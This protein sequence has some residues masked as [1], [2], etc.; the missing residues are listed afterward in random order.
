MEP[1]FFREFPI[2][3]APKLFFL[4]RVASFSFSFFLSQE[5][6]LL[7]FV[8]CGSSESLV[9]APNFVREIECKFFPF[10][11]GRTGAKDPPFA[12]FESFLF[13]FPSHRPQKFNSFP[14]LPSSPIDRR[15]E[16]PLGSFFFMTATPVLLAPPPGNSTSFSNPCSQLSPPYGHNPSSIATPGTSPPLCLDVFSPLPT[17]EHLRFSFLRIRRFF[18]GA[19]LSATAP[20]LP[21]QAHKALSFLSSISKDACA[22]SSLPHSLTFPKPRMQLTVFFERV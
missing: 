14:R 12:Y 7:S 15:R 22:I 21:E 20:L 3:R 4:R 6:F 16:A 13:P 19:N 5:S 11:P 18:S 8:A 9:L 10:L 1:I 17:R 2:E